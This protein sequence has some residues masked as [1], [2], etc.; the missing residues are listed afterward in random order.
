MPQS[1]LANTGPYQGLSRHVFGSV[2]AA[3][4][5][6]SYPARA[7]PALTAATTPDAWRRPLALLLDGLRATS[8]PPPPLPGH[9][10]TEAQLGDV[11]GELGPHRAPRERG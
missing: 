11:L 2:P 3:A 4:R 10:L 8:A 5:P 9:A 6:C 1:R 7:V